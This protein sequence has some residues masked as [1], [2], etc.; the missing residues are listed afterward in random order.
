M[1]EAER[2]DGAEALRGMLT[3]SRYPRS[4]GYEP[5]WMIASMMGPNALW[6]TEALTQVLPLAQGERVLDLG[7]GKALSS[8]FLAREF[9]VQVWAADLWIKPD[10]NWERIREAK[11]ADR[12]FPLYTEAHALPFAEGFFDAIMSMDAYHYFG[13]SDLYLSYLARFLR[14]EGRIGIVVPGL[15]HDVDP[16]PPP[17]LAPYWDAD[18]CTFHSPDWWRKHWEK[19]QA[20]SVEHA[21]WLPHGWDDWLIWNRV[22]ALAGR[23][24][25]RELKLLEA[26]G[27]E[28]LGFSRIV[29]RR[30]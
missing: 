11:L 20:V 28:L 21:G 18:F 7:C 4:A 13:T 5:D 1:A 30:R 6:L 24:G 10:E 26:D 17:H 16:L 29:A 27:G 19:S 15:R 8:I 9:G 14:P 22:C 12:V 2:P 25:E 3:L 23:G